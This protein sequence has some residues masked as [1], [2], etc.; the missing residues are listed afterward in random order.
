MILGSLALIIITGYIVEALRLAA[1]K[2]E[3]AVYSPIGNF[4][5]TVFYSGMSQEQLHSQHFILWLFHG[6]IAFDFCCLDSKHLFCSYVQ[7]SDEYLL[8]KTKP[9][10]NIPRIAEIEE[11]ESFGI[12][13]FNQFNW[14]FRLNFDACTECGR[15]TAVCPVN[16]AGGPL[17]PRE[18]ILSLKKTMHGDYKTI[19]E[20]LI[21]NAVSK[22]ALLACTTCGACVLNNVLQGLKSA[23]QLCK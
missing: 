6:I 9:R 17:D 21:G 22:D 8:A 20:P 11:Q 2:P 23:V 13:K 14:Q 16:R 4:L 10:G 19:D 12:S 15:C 7:V 5:A 1:E 18:I 3:Y